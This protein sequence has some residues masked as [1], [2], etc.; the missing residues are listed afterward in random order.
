MAGGALCFCHQALRLFPGMSA[1]IADIPVQELFC[2]KIVQPGYL[3]ILRLSAAVTG[4]VKKQV[5]FL[6]CIFPDRLVQVEQAGLCILFPIPGVGTVQGILYTAFVPGFIRIKDNPYIHF[7]DLPKAGA[8]PAHPVGIIK[9]KVG[10]RSRS[11]LPYP[12]KKQP[13]A[14]I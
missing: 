12:G 4:A 13:Q 1:F 9:G 7:C 10:R 8:G 6:F 11:G 14:G 2:K 5:I 3:R